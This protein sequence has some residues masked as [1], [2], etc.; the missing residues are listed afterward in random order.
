MQLRYAFSS[1][2]IVFTESHGKETNYR[3]P[4]CPNV[5]IFQKLS[6]FLV[7]ARLVLT[8]DKKTR[9]NILVLIKL[10]NFVNVNWKVQMKCKQK[11]ILSGISF[12]RIRVSV[13]VKN[14]LGWEF[15]VYDFLQ[16]VT[17]C[18]IFLKFCF[19]KYSGDTR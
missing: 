14:T 8:F 19:W 1:G 10:F 7:L 16:L 5:L 13:I 11:I 17:N 6:L 3:D 2:L 4:V 9:K 12:A 18:K 15:P